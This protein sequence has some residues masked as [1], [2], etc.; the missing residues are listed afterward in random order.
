MIRRVV[1]RSALL[2]ALI[3]VCSAHIGSPD[4][5]Y[6][7]TAGPYPIEV[8]VTA[9]TVVPGIAKISIFVRGEGVQQ[10]S[11]A[12]NKFD[13][14]AASPPPDI[15]ERDEKNPEMYKT[16]LWVMSGGSNGVTVKV[17]GTK[18]SGTAVIPVVVV[19]TKILQMDKPMGAGLAAVGLFLLVG[20]ITIIASAARESVLEPGD[21]PDAKR[22][23]VARI[24]AGVA[25]IF[26]STLL[27]GGWTW[28]NSEENNY[29]RGLFKPLSATAGT[30][31]TVAGLNIRMSIAESSWIKRRDT[32]WLRVNGRST[33]TPLIP[34]HGKL[35]HMF[36]VG[37]P[38]NVAFAHLHPVTFDSVT[39]TSSL[40]ALPAGKYRAFGDIVHESGFTQTLSS[41]FEIPAGAAVTARV[42]DPDD[43][44]LIHA[45]ADGV[46]E[47]RLEDG[48]TMKWETT[49]AA[50]TAGADAG[51]RFAVRGSDGKA[52]ELEP[53]M[54][55]AGHAV[56]MRDDGGVFVHLH[57]S[58]TISM[59]SQM[60]LTM[61]QAGDSVS[62]TLS[63]RMTG[64]AGMA[65]SDQP[66]E[67]SGESLSFP[68][69]FPQTGNYLVWVQVK[70]GGKIQ[71]GVFRVM[72]KT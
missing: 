35:M 46:S 14:T 21:E 53:Y 54:G 3:F 47:F 48:A 58:G 20:A 33:Y 32:A 25:T 65:M 66:A 2:T 37:G 18:G 29:K 52:V 26:L 45:A 19:A 5:W 41:S 34:D 56:V 22:R 28:W 44:S 15:A 57:P 72:V 69:A 50:R 38:E 9:P 55:M 1:T 42:T 49:S 67:F 17:N 7:G 8:Q 6:S 62:G 12:V 24:A 31:A 36:V 63:K 39:F 43:S 70:L 10:V 68:Y 51:L 11:A 16:E 61:R 40:P 64:M 4:A 60:A 59:A 13:A 27:F 71:T 23:R 30:E